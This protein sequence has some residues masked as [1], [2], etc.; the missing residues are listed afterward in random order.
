MLPWDAIPQNESFRQCGWQSFWEYSSRLAS[1]VNLHIFSD[2]F[3]T[4]SQSLS[5]VLWAV[6]TAITVFLKVTVVPPLRWN[7]NKCCLNVQLFHFRKILFP[8]LHKLIIC[9]LAQFTFL[10]I[11]SWTFFLLKFLLKLKYVLFD[12]SLCTY[13]CGVN[14][15]QPPYNGYI[16]HDV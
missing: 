8:P 7:I 1:S 9:A 6:V 10:I 2:A 16:W 3:V 14:A 5:L 4:L 11:Q 15:C 12:L 13:S